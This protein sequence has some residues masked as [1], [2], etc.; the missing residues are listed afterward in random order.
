MAFTIS[1]QAESVH[2]TRARQGNAHGALGPPF[3]VK[4][5]LPDS[6]L[7]TLPAVSAAGTLHVILQADDGN[8]HLFAYRRVVLQ[9]TP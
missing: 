7:A 2:F 5:Y 1:P 6:R 9:V 8:P 3:A 4:T